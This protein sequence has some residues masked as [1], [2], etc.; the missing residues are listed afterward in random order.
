MIHATYSLAAAMLRS[1]GS[2]DLTERQTAE[3]IGVEFFADFDAS[4]FREHCENPRER[5]NAVQLSEALRN[6]LPAEQRRLIF[7][8]LCAIAL[9]NGEIATDETALLN[10]IANA[11]GLDRSAMGSGSD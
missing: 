5:L 8:Y 7:R 2:V 6:R 4:E 1:D 9:A 11:M 3:R 10:R